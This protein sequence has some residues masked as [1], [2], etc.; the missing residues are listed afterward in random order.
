VTPDKN[1]F[2][3]SP[4]YELHIYW[5][6]SLGFCC[7][8][9]HKVYPDNQAGK[10][11]IKNMTIQEW[12][13]SEPMRAARMSMFGNKKNS[14]CTRC[15]FE[16]S[17]SNASRRHRANQKSVIFTRTA[18]EESYLQSPGQK[19]FE[20]TR[21]LDGDYDGMPVDLHI[22]LG[23]YCNLTCKMCNPQASSSIAV[24]HIKWGIQSARQYVGTDWTRDS[25]V[26]NR[27]IEELS[28]ITKL[29]NVHFMGGETLITKRFE[30][31]VDFMLSKG[32][33]DLNF[34]FVTNGT[35]FNQSLIEKLL[36][37]K[38]IGIEV[39]IE[40]L[41]DHN[42]YQRQGTNTDQ[43]RENIEKYLQYCD[44][45]RVTLTARPAI[46]LLTIG[47]YHTLLKYCLDKSLVVKSLLVYKPDY[48]DP[49]ILPDDVKEMYIT[50]YEDFL[51]DN[52]LQKVDCSIDYN[53]SDPHQLP[54]IIKNQVIQCINAL[55]IQRPTNADQLL[56]EMVIWCRRWDDVHG[57]D[58]V[59]LYPELKTTFEKYGY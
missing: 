49:S 33:T 4:W 42:A 46:S 27:V 40:T 54:Q 36:K 51:I 19:K 50:R 2:C 56:K 9:S 59:T 10:Y 12:M 6:G 16:E 5:D 3:N 44:N 20:K 57:Y 58:A 30:D 8:E 1:I 53:E 11:N 22:D 18:F 7:Q 26:W 28:N 29:K 47:N 21:A 13:N 38:R 41:T 32:R 31:F 23:N 43:V 15:Y 55:K 45:D 39:S 24:Q 14:Y 35:T 48:Y 34:S 25:A 52:D 37:F 17:V